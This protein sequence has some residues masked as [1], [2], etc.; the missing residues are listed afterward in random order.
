MNIA[1]SEGC[2]LNTGDFAAL[3]IHDPSAPR[4]LRSPDQH[5]LRNS[6]PQA[7]TL[8]T[9]MPFLQNQFERN[10]ITTSVD[11]VFNWARKSSL[12]PLSFGLACCAVEM[13]AS[14]AS[15]FD[16]ARFGA[17]VFRPSPRQADLMI[18]AG[19]VTLK[20][21]PVLRRLYDQM[22]D[23]KWVISMG[24]CSSVGGPFN[25]Y[26]V[27]QGV[28][29][30][31]PVDVYVLGCP[32]RPENLFYALLKLQD[33]IDR[34]TTLVKRPTEVH[35]EESMLAD[36]KKQVMISQQLVNIA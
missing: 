20:M 32:P 34:G 7:A 13:I 33:K 22:P 18:V 11:Y 1:P 31:V 15:R 27:L 16:I 30:I 25:T 10:I 8:E 35:L 4:G 29:K 21:A 19:T 6:R 14:T 36:F 24:A 3:S 9:G 2:N 12:W 23:P 28:D 26:S 17:E 5:P